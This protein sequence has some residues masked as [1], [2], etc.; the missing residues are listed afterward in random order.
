M[1]KS[2]DVHAPGTHAGGAAVALAGDAGRGLAGRGGLEREADQMADRLT[3]AAPRSA[4]VGSTHGP[5]EPALRREMEGHFG[6]DFSQVRIHADAS[7]ARIAGAL[8]AAALTIGSDVVFNSG[9]FAPGTPAGRRLLAHELTHVVQQQRLAAPVVQRQPLGGGTDDV[10]GALAWESYRQSVTLN[11]F[12]SDSAV[13]T[14]AHGEQLDAYKLRVQTLLGLYPESFF[15]LIGHTDATASEAHNKALGQ[16]RADAVKARLTSGDNA[17]PA[18][19]VSAGSLGETALSV[20]TPGREA[21]NRRVEIIPTLRR[22]ALRLA[23]L[24]PPDSLGG[25]GATAGPLDGIRGTGPGFVTD[26]DPLGLRR[27]RVPGLVTPEHNWLE[28]ALDRDPLI[29]SLPSWM[30]D[31]LK[32]ALAEADEKLAEKVIDA[33]PLDD[34][35]KAALQA[36]VKGLLQRAKG[37]TWKRPEAPPR[38]ADFGPQ[39]EFPKFPGQVLIPG[40]KFEF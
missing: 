14:P 24:T 15:T 18:Q 39:Q 16:S 35:A 12:D 6:H 28:D 40:P 17:V 19:Q 29:R 34:K 31:K 32:G 27:P 1:T 4:A 22:R 23:P 9:R 11:A 7:A 33:L 21:R 5:L 2:H 13:L 20:P 25:A 8:D 37:K 3:A 36:I 10:Q 30:G 26:P 38:G